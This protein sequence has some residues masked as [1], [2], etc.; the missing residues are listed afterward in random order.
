MFPMVLILC[1]FASTILGVTGKHL[2]DTYNTQII[3]QISETNSFITQS[4]GSFMDKAY[5]I[6]EEL[7]YSDLVLSMNGAVQM[8]VVT[9]TAER[10]DYFELIYIQD[11][12]G[13][14]TARSSGELGN[15]ADRWWFSQ[16]M[17]LKK[18]FISK[19]YYSINT[20]MACASI[21]YPLFKNSKMTGILATDIKLT[22]LQSLVEEYSETGDD[23]ISFIIDG[24][25]TVLAHPESVYYEELYNYKN[26]TRT[27]AQK[28]NDGNVLY[29]E[30]GNI[31]TKDVPVD[32]PE[33]FSSMVEKVMSGKS[34][35]AEVTYNGA[36]YYS[37]YSPVELDGHSDTWSVITLYNKENA[38]S[39]IQKVNK[40]GISV[41]IIAVILAILLIALITKTI[42]KP[43]KL[44]LDRLKL[45]AEG[46][47]ATFVPET[48]GHDESAGLLT[49]LNKTISTLNNIMH[50]INNFASR[51]ADGNFNG[52][53]LDGFQGEFSHLAA[54]LTSISESM[55]ETI[56]QIDTASAAI[57]SCARSTDISAQS[58]AA[59]ATDQA[60]AVNELF[61]SLT[62]ITG[63][64]NTN[65]GHTREADKMMGQTAMEL[66][67]SNTNL[68]NLVNSMK[69]IEEN[70]NEIKSITDL[71]QNIA[72]QTNLLSM[73]AS[74]EASRTGT[75]G[76]GFAVVASEIRDLAEK[77]NT[78]ATDTAG[79]ISKTC[80]NVKDGME[81]L[82]LT[83]ASLVNAADKNQETCSLINSI[84]L[85]TDEQ[86]E[87]ITHIQSTLE[88]ISSVTHNNSQIAQDNA[89]TSKEMMKHAEKLKMM[90]DRYNY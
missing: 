83:V 55:G 56:R 80:N 51:I 37:S 1:I 14:Q 27:I 23:R 87:A 49:S 67:E 69:T 76:K 18:P 84:A 66:E 40:S 90:L 77:C 42:T 9:G 26:L 29:D 61:S 2:K 3:N 63:K 47:L 5:S 22:T 10:N 81:S 58:L 43:V 31:L 15:R 78:A 52:T 32:V 41:T 54:L 68:Q 44:C 36:T 35:T 46:D 34:G 24:E 17:E 53:I 33:N 20:D 48:R 60:D 45:L 88:H 13:D 72:S 50:E 39:L 79:L 16:T 70:S 62:E 82:D 74:I 21:F 86:S 38:L 71:M 8:P 30:S 64:I 89:D 85:A 57:I 73:N 7:A 75:A 65:A 59:S 4:V 19:S 28:D 25:G 12:N 11:T 6:T